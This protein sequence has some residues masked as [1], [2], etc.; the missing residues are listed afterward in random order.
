MLKQKIKLPFNF[1][2]FFSGPE[3]IQENKRKKVE[4][5]YIQK[6]SH[7][8]Y[9]VIGPQTAERTIKPLMYQ[10]VRYESVRKAETDAGVSRTEIYRRLRYPKKKDIYYLKEAETPFGKIPVFCKKR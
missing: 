3:W 9:N 6:N 4:E 5:D 8:C 7:R 2:F 1:L 10:G